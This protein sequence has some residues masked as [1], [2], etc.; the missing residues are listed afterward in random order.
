[1]TEKNKVA[2]KKETLTD[3]SPDGQGA[4]PLTRQQTDPVVLASPVKAL[5]MLEPPIQPPLI[6]DHDRPHHGLALYYFGAQANTNIA[7]CNE[8]NAIQSGV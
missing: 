1:M 4:R 8:R 3:T 2:P 7:A 6:D 5:R